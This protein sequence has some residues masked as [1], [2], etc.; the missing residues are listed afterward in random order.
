MLVSDVDSLFNLISASLLPPK[1]HS[2]EAYLLDVPIANLLIQYHTTR[3]L[4]DIVHHSRLAVVD[5][6]C[7]ALLLSTVVLD[8]YD[9]ADFVV[10]HEGG[11]AD[12]ALLTVLAGESVVVVSM[13][14][15]D[16]DEGRRTHSGFPR[17][18]RQRDPSRR[19]VMGCSRG[20][21][22]AVQVVN[23]QR[24]GGSRLLQPKSAAR[25]LVPRF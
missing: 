12:H 3:T 13:R 23:V 5:L 7:H 14:G 2:I 20:V 1:T 15:F 8:V 17:G 10:L 24:C 11:Q 25:Y 22:N 6:V 4:G 18:D 16:A 21:G 19:C 9:V